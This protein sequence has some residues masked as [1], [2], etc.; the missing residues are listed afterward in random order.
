MEDIERS[1]RLL[2]ALSEAAQA[3]QRARTLEEVYRIVGEE[4]ARLD[5]Q[6]LVFTLTEDRASLAL[7]HQTLDS[8]LLRAAEKLTG[9]SARDFRVPFV[10]GGFHDRVVFGGQAL[11][12]ESI[13]ER[14][15][16][17]I[18]GLARPLAEQVASVVGLEQGIYAPLTVGGE[19]H[20]M[21]VVTGTGLSVAD[22]PAVTGF[23]NQTAIALEN[24]QTRQA[25]A[26]TRQA[27]AEQTRALRAS[28]DTKH[29]E[30]KLRAQY[31]S[32]PIPTGTWQKVGEN[33][34][35]VDYND[36]LEEATQGKIA[37]F[38][39]MKARDLYQDQPD[40]V[41]GL[42]RCLDQRVVVE[43][44]MFYRYKST[45]EGRHLA[46]RYAFAPPDL[47]LVYT[48]DITERKQALAELER[49]L[50]EL[51]ALNTMATIVNQSLEVGEILDW[52]IE[53]ALRQVGVEAAGILL[54]EKGAASLPSVNEGAA[55]LRLVAYQGITEEFAR[56]VSRQ[57]VGQGMAGRV[58]QTGEPVVI[59]HAAEY[60]GAL[61]AF[62]ERERIQSV[63]SVPL[64]GSAGVIGV[65]N[66]G[67][68]NPDFF[69]AP[70]LELLVGLGRQ[71]ATGVEK[72]RLYDETRAWA[73]E[74]ETRVEER[75]ADIALV[76]ALNE[77]SNRGES[78]QEII[79]L[80]TRETQRVFHSNG[81]TVYLLSEGGYK[82]SE[83]G[84]KTSDGKR[85]TMQNLTLPPAAVRQ[86]EKLIGR[87]I[88]PIAI[89]FEPGS[90]YWDILQAGEP[91]LI[92]DP[93]TMQRLIGEFTRTPHLPEAARRALD[94]LIPQIHRLIGVQSV[95]NVPLISEG[96][97]IGLLDV[98]R[99]EP[100]TASELERLVTIAGQLT[101]IIRRKQTEQ[102]LRAAKEKYESLVQNIPDA[103]YSA[104]P[105]ETGTTTFMSGR[106]EDWTGHAPEDFYRDPETWPKSIHPDDL[107]DAVGGYVAACQSGEEYVSE[108]RVV[109]KD[110][111]E[112]RW[113]RDHG[114]PI[115]DG[116]GHV[117]RFDGIVTDVTARKQAEEQL[118]RTMKDLE[119]SN[120]ELEQFAYVASHDLQEPLRMVSSFT[121]L[122]ARRYQ[123][124]LDDDANDFIA[125]AVDG[126]NRMQHLINDLLAY[127]RVG[128]R[129]KSLAPSDC[130]SV[131]GQAR[132]NLS[133]AIEESHALVTNEE[134]P[135]VMADAEQLVQVFQNLIG[136]A[137]KFRGE[138]PPR[139]HVSAERADDADR[140][141]RRHP[142]EHEWVFSVRDNGIGIDPQYH[143]RI[144]VIFQQLHGREE[145][146]GT[147][148]G[149][150]IC[151]RIVA[152]H[153][154][155]IWVES[156]LGEGSTFRFTLPTKRMSPGCLSSATART[157]GV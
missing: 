137:I 148:I 70:G 119:R 145:Y 50:A 85:L 117:V 69:D 29:L 96:K 98:S 136:N 115:K 47:V 3:V 150:A 95:L 154:G 18:P 4:V 60:P 147:G 105:D 34:V 130:N 9:L 113:V 92:D 72:A 134:L 140:S 144:F 151:K 22:V 142:R 68:A 15:A 153:G 66:L 8:P 91:R 121:Q 133:V 125:Y 28:A 35:L 38:L 146:P 37:G 108:Y 110:T 129:R 40:I 84:Y 88:P 81:A 97:P 94:T 10:P 141:G 75:T 26:Q 100:F 57:K 2:L 39:G 64:I 126:A 80:L 31:K 149:L 86:I 104:L 156:E 138:E 56:T 63:A 49:R 112:T 120:E 23:A 52:A 59:G 73:A 99:R 54:L 32:M 62:L 106:W 127:S 79:A 19:A 102:A 135:T 77:A 124:Q 143:E 71:I 6:A 101:A 7:A 128:T 65:M 44:E 21:L 152:R 12:A 122:L 13:V 20:G 14:I 5:Y 67:T 123:D 116:N 36:A 30:E 78:L 114:V 27:L 58:A 155:R 51:S 83:G 42:S 93:Q 41:E 82:T 43:Q 157:K 74:L 131:L 90:L 24:A 11:F 103:V 55:E 111:G 118:K 87:D 46:V 89:P 45:G 16:E 109:H 61:Q 17:T 139:I 76:N 33:F 132:A 48:E 53:E 25:N 1:H 107:E